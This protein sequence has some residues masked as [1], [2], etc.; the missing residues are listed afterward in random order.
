MKILYGVQATGNGHITRARVMAPALANENVDV[1]WLFSGRAPEAYFDMDS[2][3]P[4]QTRPGL[5]LFTHRGKLK[6]WTTATRN[7][8]TRFCSDTRAL[9]LTPYDMVLTDFEPITAWAAKQQKAPCVGLA[10]QYAFHYPIPRAGENWV[11]RRVMRNFA[12]V[13]QAMGIHWHHF[14]QPILPPIID[15]QTK[16]EG[17][18]SGVLVYLTAQAPEELTALFHQFPQQPFQVYAPVAETRTLGNVTFR[19]FSRDG[20][21]AHLRSCYGVICNTGFELISEVLHLG[22][23]LYTLPTRGHMEQLSNAAALRRLGLVKTRDELDYPGLT[24]WLQEP[25]PMAIHFPDVASLLA[26]RLAQGHQ[27][28]LDPDWL[29]AIW[30]RIRWPKGIAA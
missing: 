27:Q 23:R 24:A 26:E 8:L 5:T 11:G 9:D 18:D 13:S 19:P 6:Y 10:H 30:Q 12:P 2:F 15:T 28:M 22:K 4:H 1:D 20:F 16:N 21:Q 7:R 17:C 3:G 25:E 29:R 14:N